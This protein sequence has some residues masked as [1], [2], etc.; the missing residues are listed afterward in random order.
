MA[1]SMAIR[2]NRT[3]DFPGIS[4]FMM[5]QTRK[6]VA[7]TLNAG[8]KILIQTIFHDI[9]V[10]LL[11]KCILTNKFAMLIRNRRM[12]TDCGIRVTCVINNATGREHIVS[13]VHIRLS[14]PI[15]PVASTDTPN[16]L[17]MTVINVVSIIHLVNGM[18]CGGY[19]DSHRSNMSERLSNIGRVM[20]RMRK[21]D[22]TAL[23]RINI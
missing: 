6:A 14:P 19:F 4:P 16:G 22:M 11:Q 9:P 23:L 20:I 13:V 1:I 7:P 3:V 10:C 17:A 21:N 8:N 15:R 12:N 2:A 18:A 5:K